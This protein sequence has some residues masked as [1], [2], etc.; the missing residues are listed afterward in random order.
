LDVRFY[1]ETDIHRRWIKISLGRQRKEQIKV[2]KDSCRSKEEKDTQRDVLLLEIPHSFR[3]MMIAI[4]A[5]IISLVIGEEITILNVWI[6]TPGGGIN[7]ASL[8]KN[9]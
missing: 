5:R 1:G 7:R 4:V 8:F 2:G 6:I 9:C 3:F